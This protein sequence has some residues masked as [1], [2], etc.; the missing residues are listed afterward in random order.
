MRSRIDKVL[1]VA[2]REGHTFRAAD[3]KR[4]AQRNARA[5]APQAA[6]AGRLTGRS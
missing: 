2:V 1:P 6:K 3:L 4:A 5:E